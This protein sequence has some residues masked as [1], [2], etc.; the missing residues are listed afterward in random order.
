MAQLGS[1]ARPIICR[2]QDESRAA[3]VQ[4]ICAEHGFQFIIG[5][6]PDKPENLFDLKKALK[7]LP[8]HIPNTPAKVS[9]NDYC[10]CGS[11][12]KYK[13]CCGATQPAS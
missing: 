1:K 13:K 11:N 7:S 8:T 4:S 5:L 3:E 12:K 2:V 9:P 10:P 6:E